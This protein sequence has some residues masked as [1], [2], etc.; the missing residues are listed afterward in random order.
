MVYC[1]AAK[2]TAGEYYRK[3]LKNTD[4]TVEGI[5]IIN[6][7]LNKLYVN[8]SSNNVYAW[9]GSN[10]V[11]VSK[12]LG[13]GESSTTAYAGN[14]GKANREDIDKIISGDIEVGKAAN[15]TTAGYAYNADVAEIANSLWFEDAIPSGT[16]V[17]LAGDYHKRDNNDFDDSDT[18]NIFSF[19]DKWVGGSVEGGFVNTGDLYLKVFNSLNGNVTYK[20]PTATETRAGLISAENNNYVNSL[21]QII[22][23]LT[24][25]MPKIVEIPYDF[26]DDDLDGE[27]IDI[28][29][30]LFNS[31]HTKPELVS[32]KIK[33][34][35]G[36]NIRMARYSGFR[37]GRD[38]W[39]ISDPI[40]GNFYQV[41]V[42][43]AMEDEWKYRVSITKVIIGT[44]VTLDESTGTLSID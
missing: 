13:L 6:P 38:Y 12:K 17:T 3:F 19:T 34:N 21:R 28:T 42:Y 4:G 43:S 33:S 14:K 36:G 5:E 29:E 37:H 10:L 25:N 24:A 11:E 23:D 2:A 18:Y 41:D 39:L 9:S 32:L 27:I 22:A 26:I 16:F 8:S 44:Q 15:S 35:S 1:A 31:I 40:S 30:E 20:I 7:I